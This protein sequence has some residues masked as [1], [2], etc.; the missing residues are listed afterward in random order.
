MRILF[1]PFAGVVALSAY[2]GWQMGKPLSESA[3]LDHHADI[4]VQTGPD[5]AE[6][7]DC[8]GVPGEVDTVWITVIC[9]HDSGIVERTAVDRQG[10]VLME[11]D[12]PET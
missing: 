1:L 9:R 12:G 4:W 5:G 10:R 2:V 8:F 3:V 6:K 7:T 11:Q